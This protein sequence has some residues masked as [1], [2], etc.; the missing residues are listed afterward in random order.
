MG[1]ML[2]QTVAEGSRH[3]AVIRIGIRIDVDFPADA[4]V[5]PAGG[6]N[7]GKGFIIIW[8]NMQQKNLPRFYVL[9]GMES[10]RC[11]RGTGVEAHW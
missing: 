3:R 8:H 11:H 1:N 10:Q 7:A 9:H 5:M 2:L 4:A 6:S